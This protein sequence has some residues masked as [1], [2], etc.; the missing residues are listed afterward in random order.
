MDRHE[1]E[2]E[3]NCVG[4]GAMLA[5]VREVKVLNLLSLIKRKL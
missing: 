3:A 4:T 2:P 1:R 5:E